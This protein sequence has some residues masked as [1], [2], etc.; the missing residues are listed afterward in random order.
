MEGKDPLEPQAPDICVS[1][2]Q[3][4]QRVAPGQH[5]ECLQRAFEIGDVVARI[6]KH[7]EGLRRQGLRVG[8]ANSAE[9]IF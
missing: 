4:C 9:R 7:F 1:V 8:V 5:L 2:G 3:G 6:E